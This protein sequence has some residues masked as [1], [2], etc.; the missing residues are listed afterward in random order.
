MRITKIS[1]KTQRIILISAFLLVPLALL[2]TFALYPALKLL[3]YSFT[4]FNGL[5]NVYPWVGIHNYI[6]IFSNPSLFGVFLHNLSY[7]IGGLVQ[8]VL[9]LVLAL[10]LSSKVR[11]RNGFRAILF[12]PYI[13]NSVAI[14]YIFQYLYQDPGV[15]DMVLKF[16][17]LGALQADWIGNDKL[18]NWSLAFVS[19]WEF[20]PFTMVIYLAALQSLPRDMYESAVLDGAGAWQTFRFITLPNLRSIIQINLLLTV[21]GALESFNIP[22][23]MTNAAPG[24]ATFLTQTM[25]VAFVFDNYGLASAMAVV[26]VAIVVIVISIQRKLIGQGDDV[27]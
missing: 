9:A 15:L 23:I 10:F 19:L 26:L 20:L 6:E 16:V 11:F 4:S 27:V 22:F 2:S 18:V 17:G 1:Y 24:A 7:F 12:V 5:T 8:N 14:V 25:N 3:F 21:S 13:L